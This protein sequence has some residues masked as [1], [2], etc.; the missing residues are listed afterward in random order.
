[1][2]SEEL[3]SKLVLDVNYKLFIFLGNYFIILKN[4]LWTGCVAAGLNISGI[5]AEV[6]PSNI[7][8]YNNIKFK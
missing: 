7:L 1:M 6:A 5:N 8:F 2:P 3:V 4:F